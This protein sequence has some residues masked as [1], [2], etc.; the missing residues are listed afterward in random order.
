MNRKI[1]IT[2][3]IL[4]LAVGGFMTYTRVKSS[5][6]ADTTTEQ[7]PPTPNTFEA[8]SEGETFEVPDNVEPTSIKN[9]ELI[10]ENEQ[11]KIRKL[12]NTYTV[13]LYA[14]INRPDQAD[15]Y[16]A[17]LKEYKENAL[18]DLKDRGVNISTT[19]IIYEPEEATNL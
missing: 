6:Q 1:I 3:L 16:K 13:T 7:K 15:S 14:I 18:K 11:Y 4:A 12:D 8:K 2:V 10:T 5:S 9:Y 19:K 17:Q